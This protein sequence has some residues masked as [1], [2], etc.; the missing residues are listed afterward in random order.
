MARRIEPSS[1]SNMKFLTAGGEGSLTRN[2]EPCPR[3]S[4]TYWPKSPRSHRTATPLVLHQEVISR[5][6]QFGGS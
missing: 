4:L 1:G 3:S 2:S 6:Y 5:G